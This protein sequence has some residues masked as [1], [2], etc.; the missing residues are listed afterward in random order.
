MAGLHSLVIP[1]FLLVVGFLLII[2]GC[3]VVPHK[4]AWPLMSLAFYCFAPFPFFLCGGERPDSFGSSSTA[5]LFDSAGLFLGGVLTVSGPALAIVLYHT[6]VISGAALGFTLGSGLC[7]LAM[8]CI[9]AFASSGR[10]D[11]EDTNFF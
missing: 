9:I 11:D 5:T 4:N 6:A 3:T 1:A 7:F 10:D 8:S 2:L